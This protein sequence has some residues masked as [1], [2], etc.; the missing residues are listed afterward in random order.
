MN[1]TVV[2]V[3]AMDMTSCGDPVCTL[4][5]TTQTIVNLWTFPPIAL[6]TKPLKTMK[7]I[8]TEIIIALTPKATLMISMT[9]EFLKRITIMQMHGTPEIDHLPICTPTNH[10]Y[11]QS[12]PQLPPM[13]VHMQLSQMSP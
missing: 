10:L 9:I 2:L 12:L 11:Y 3:K 4:I 5:R 6:E 1:I 8:A 7:V 13:N